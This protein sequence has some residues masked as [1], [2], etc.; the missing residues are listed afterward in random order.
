MKTLEEHEDEMRKMKEIYVKNRNG[1][2]IKCPNC[3]D[4]LK[5]VDNVLLLSNPPQKRV[6]C[7]N[8]GYSTTITV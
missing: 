8:C 6:Y 3:G 2:D 5:Y 7:Y 4:E 1:T